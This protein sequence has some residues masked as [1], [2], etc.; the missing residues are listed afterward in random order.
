MHYSK[1]L[2]VLIFIVI[3]G[4]S[5][6]SFAKCSWGDSGEYPHNVDFDFGSIIVQRDTS[7]GTV[8]K[9]L[10]TDYVGGGLIGCDTAWVAVFQQTLFPGAAQDNVF[11]TNISGVG[12]RI[13]RNGR[14]FNSE[15]Q[16]PANNYLGA[17]LPVTVELIKTSTDGVEGGYLR[18]GELARMF[19]KA[20]PMY[21]MTASITGG[22]IIPVACSIKDKNISVTLEDVLASDLTEIGKTAK[23]KEFKIELECDAGARINA[24]LTGT[25]NRDSN[26]DGVVELTGAGGDGVAKGVGIQI[27]YN[28]VPMKLNENIVLK[29]SAGGQEMLPLTAQYYQTKNKEDVLAGEANATATLELTYQ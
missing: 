11:K 19:V 9:T 20:E 8:L 7:Q 18:T 4:I 10:S 15:M 17:Y 27:L 21:Y 6:T 16:A 29:T 14:Y 12:I 24:K 2:S 25:Q 26:V 1:L 28:G 13:S 5:S 3:T 22:A 23:P